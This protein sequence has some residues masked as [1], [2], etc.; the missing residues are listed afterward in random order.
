MTSETGDQ[1]G[2]DPTQSPVLQALRNQYAQDRDVREREHSQG[3][4]DWELYTPQQ[5][6]TFAFLRNLF[7]RGVFNP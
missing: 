3:L 5:R 1:Q 6:K 4:H 7:R 2:W